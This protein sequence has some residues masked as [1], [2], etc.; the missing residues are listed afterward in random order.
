MEQQQMRDRDLVLPPHTYAFVLDNTKGKV[1][2]YVGPYKS[3]LSNT[4][5]LVTWDEDDDR[6]VVEDNFEEAIHGFLK[7]NEGQY[8]ILNDPASGAVQHPLLGT[9]SDTTELA[10]GRKVIIPG[11]VAFSLWPG[12]TGA[13]IDGH[14]LKSNQY[15]LVRVYQPEQARMNAE[16]A[17][18]G[19]ADEKKAAKAVAKQFTM[20]QL[21]VIKGTDVS[22]YIPP[23]GIEVVGSLNTGV[24]PGPYNDYGMT[25]VREAA[26]IERLEYVILLD[27]DGQKRYV[28]GPDVVFPEPTEQFVT[29]EADNRKFRAIEL[30]EQSGLYI[31]VIADYTDEI[32]KTEHKAGEEL[33]ITG[34]DQSL[35][36]ANANHIVIE[37]GEQRKHHAIAIP[38][39]EGRYVLDRNTG[40]VELIKG[41]KMFLPDPRHQ[42]VVRRVLDVST[43]EVMYPGNV[44]AAQVNA[45]LTAE[46]ASTGV[47]DMLAAATMDWYAAP[48]TASNYMAV[49]AH[50]HDPTR[51]VKARSAGVSKAFGGET[52]KRGTTYTKPRTVTLETKYEGAVAIN[53]WPGYAVLVTDKTG[54]RR[55]E[56][57]PKAVL[58]EYDETPMVLSLST[59]RPK[60]DDD[61]LH[62]VYLRT[63]NNVVSDRVTVETADLVPVTLDLSYR[64]NFEGEADTHWFDVENYVGLLTDH[65]RSR[66]RNEA[67][68]TNVKEF[69]ANYIDI[70]RDCLLGKQPD[71]AQREGRL[72]AENNMRLYDVEV[73]NAKINDPNVG[74]LLESATKEAMIGAIEL[75]QAEDTH[76]R[77]TKLEA[78]KRATLKERDKTRDAEAKSHL[79]ALTCR[80]DERLL[81]A[82]IEFD[83]TAART[84]TAELHR[85]QEAMDYRQKL[86]LQQELD[87]AELTRL[88][89]EVDEFLRRVGAL[90]GG[91]IEALNNMGD[92][93]FADGLVRS[94]GPVALATGVTTADLLSKAFE[95]TPLGE[96]TSALATRP[97]ASH[98]NGHSQLAESTS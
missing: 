95:G 49:S 19:G 90:N 83:Q 82:R 21:I 58:L 50:D 28:I 23:T 79:E 45:A 61:L 2:V 15:L 4:D 26:T 68:R 64:V 53:I 67:K 10:H 25:F 44:E 29:D 74:L 98:A 65:C 71:G 56:A 24:T 77:D 47:N 84:K 7:A 54:H 8:I 92:K 40:K 72:F 9:T 87:S 73:P 80:L 59:G 39:G 55:V 85:A 6:F 43:V 11:P 20:G 5:R 52:T 35:Y 17:I 66:L 36:F 75:G 57:G 69:Y 48:A 16:S 97:Y 60:T 91:M 33:F 46:L 93:A 94:L 22:F 42:V 34:K 41:P 96:M 18:V 63:I 37:Y 78:L 76:G 38:T 88:H 31:K 13:V 27:E 51:G 62:T 81:E 3:S 32:L 89:A 70:A 30:N 12:Q 14:H 86:A 1:S